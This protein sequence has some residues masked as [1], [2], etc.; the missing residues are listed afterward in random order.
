MSPTATADAIAEVFEF[1]EG[2]CDLTI[3][4]LKATPSPEPSLAELV[5]MVTPPKAPAMAA[6]PRP[7]RWKKK[8]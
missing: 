6:T 8:R 2:N 3:L 4:Q 5:S 1:V 7:G